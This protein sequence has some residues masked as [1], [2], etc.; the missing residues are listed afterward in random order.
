MNEAQHKIVNL[1]QSFF[2]HQF[3][4]VFVCLM[5]GPR[6]SL[7]FQCGPEMPKGWTSL[8]NLQNPNILPETIN[9]A[10]IFPSIR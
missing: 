2:V 3:P 10:L 5:C 9:Y 6:Q 1:L 7:F 4:L 8:P